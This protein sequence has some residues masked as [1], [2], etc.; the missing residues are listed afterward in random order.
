MPAP[1][2]LVCDVR[3]VLL[4]ELDEPSQQTVPLQGIGEEP[5][6]LIVVPLVAL[7]I[8]L[9]LDRNLERAGQSV[10][11]TGHVSTR[12]RLAGAQTR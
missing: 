8:H 12:P 2:V 5:R 1:G 3:R 11:S 9:P 4:E 7:M 10:K 6:K